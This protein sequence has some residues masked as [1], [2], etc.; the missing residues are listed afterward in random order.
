MPDWLLQAY[1]DAHPHGTPVG[2]ISTA[3][4]AIRI[5]NA[6]LDKAPVHEVMVYHVLCPDLVLL[7]FSVAIPET[8]IREWASHLEEQAL[9]QANHH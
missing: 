5:G 8:E 3:E 7:R 2:P 6:V 1:R 4:I 9:G